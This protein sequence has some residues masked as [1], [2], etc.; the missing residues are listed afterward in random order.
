MVV[1]GGPG[2]LEAARVAALRGH[3][4]S[5]YEMSDRLGGQ[6][7]LAAIPPVKQET[8]LWIQYLITQVRKAGVN[9]NMKTEV[10]PAVVEQAKPDVVIV[11][12]GAVPLIP[13]DLRGTGK[14]NVVTAQDVLA[15]KVDFGRMNKVVV[16]GGGRVGS[17]TADLLAERGDFSFV[18]RREVTIVEMLPEMAFDM[19]AATRYFLMG[20]LRADDVKMITSATVKEILDDGVVFTRNGVEETLHGMDT[21]V[22]ALGARPVETLSQRIRDK[23]AE[24]YVIG[25]AKEPRR[26]L[27]A[28]AEG[29]G[30]A[31]KI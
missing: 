19:Y 31:R 29:A 6:L 14:P 7:N 4:V 3:Q 27:E 22:L 20:R 8:A 30:I 17:E 16:V 1:G 2:G 21:V 18:Q 26:A 25:D 28:I 11:A 9:V 15:S 5:L 13:N 10:T 24:V 12:T 23:V